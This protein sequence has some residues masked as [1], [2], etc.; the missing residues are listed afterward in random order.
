LKTIYKYQ[1]EFQDF[2]F[3][4]NGEYQESSYKKWKMKRCQSKIYIH[5]LFPKNWFKTFSD[6]FWRA[7]NTLDFFFVIFIGVENL[8]LY[9]K[10]TQMG[11]KTCRDS[12]RI[13]LNP[14]ERVFFFDVSNPY[15]FKSWF[16]AFLHG[17]SS[18]LHYRIGP[19]VILFMILISFNNGAVSRFLLLYLFL[20]I[21]FVLCR[22]YFIMIQFCSIYIHTKNNE[23]D[24]FITVHHG[25]HHF[26]LFGECFKQNFIIFNHGL[27][28]YIFP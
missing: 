22:F 16:S 28:I 17:F 12:I 23:K 5:K 20:H 15:R 18:F 27:Y 26:S 25:F 21:I 6:S 10:L 7:L 4:Q 13:T 11:F 14:K 1:D 24:L 3:K 9:L 19:L 2:F 8:I